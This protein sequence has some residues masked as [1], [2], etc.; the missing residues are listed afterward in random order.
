M[1]VTRKAWGGSDSRS[2]RARWEPRL[3]LPCYR[4]KKP[5]LPTQPWHVEHIHDRALGGVW[6]ES[7]EWVS[8]AHCNTSAGG[9]L[10]A[11]MVNGWKRENNVVMATER[12]RG[13]RGV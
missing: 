5:V 6:D 9:R 7:N 8:H 3:P 12:A 10:G 1:K 13:I 4:C 11:A 2:A